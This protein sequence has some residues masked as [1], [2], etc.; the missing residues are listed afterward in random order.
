MRKLGIAGGVAATVLGATVVMAAAPA[1]AAT[2]TPAG[3]PVTKTAPVAKSAPVTKSAPA[4]TGAT[5]APVAATANPW[6]ADV[7]PLTLQGNA[8][9]VK[10]G[11]GTGTLTMK[12]QGLDPLARW[13]VTIVLG[14]TGS[15]ESRTSLFHWTSS[16]IDR[17]G[18]GTLS[19]RL[20]KDEFASIAHA[21]TADGLIILVSDGSRESLATFPKA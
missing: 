5:R 11:N 10:H 16:D 15:F 20:T 2:P 17:L 8:T 18:N 9:F 13:T 14:G 12:M 1:P 19:V 21:R 7:M 3:E 4:A 6:S